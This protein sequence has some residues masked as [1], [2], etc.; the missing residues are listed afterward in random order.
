[1]YRDII[2]CFPLVFFFFF[3]Y[4]LLKHRTQ[5]HCTKAVYCIHVGRNCFS[6]L[7]SHLSV[8]KTTHTDFSALKPCRKGIKNRFHLRKRIQNVMSSNSISLTVS[9]ILLILFLGTFFKFPSYK[10]KRQ[11]DHCIMRSRLLI[12]F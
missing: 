2:S 6:F 12:V 9:K 11:T 4:Y 5:V 7:C 8:W 10:T 1:M 3:P